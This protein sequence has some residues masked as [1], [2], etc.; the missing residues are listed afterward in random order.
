MGEHAFHRGAHVSLQALR[1]PLLPQPGAERPSRFEGQLGNQTG[2]VRQ[3]L[4]Q[5][6]TTSPAAA[7]PG[8]GLLG[9]SGSQRPTQATSAQHRPQPAQRPASL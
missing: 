7:R 8:Y 1:L 5:T 6:G 2:R 3:Y 4:F 9:R